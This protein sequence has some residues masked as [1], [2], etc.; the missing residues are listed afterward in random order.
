MSK[1]SESTSIATFDDI[2]GVQKKNVS[3]LR[4]H[5]DKC[6]DFTNKNDSPSNRSESPQVKGKKRH[7]KRAHKRSA[8][9]SPSQEDRDSQKYDDKQIEACHCL[10]VFGLSSHTEE[11][12]LR[13]VFS[14]FGDIDKLCLIYDKQTGQS[15]GFGF[16]YF[17]KTADAIIARKET[18][19]LVLGGRHIRV[20]YSFTLQPHPSTPGKYKGHRRYLVIK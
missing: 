9:S 6:T 5:R 4:S 16:V 17:K 20:D 3:S 15:K 18:Q 11:R 19:G 7:K 12:D 14:T 8:S 1:V 10:G 2:K 13:E